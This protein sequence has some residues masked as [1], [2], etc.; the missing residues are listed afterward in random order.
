M[1]N[2]GLVSHVA[3]GNNSLFWSD[4]WL[5]G[6]CISD[7][8]PTVVEAVPLKTRQQRTVAEALLEQA[9][10]ADI[11]GC[12]SLSMIGLF[13]YFQLWDMMQDILLSKED[14]QHSWRLEGSGQFTSKS[15]YRAFF[16]GST[17]F[18]PWL[19]I[20]KTWDPG[21]CKVFLWLAIRN[22]CW[23]ADRLQKR[24]LPHPDKCVLCDQ[25]VETVQHI[26]TSCLFARDFW[27]KILAPL[28]LFFDEYRR[29]SPQLTFI[30]L[31]TILYNRVHDT[32][33]VKKKMSKITHSRYSKKGKKRS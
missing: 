28:D 29:G 1:F 12:L 8:A 2:I 24:G 17:T 15:A 9:W 5:M 33:K 14:N 22:R 23:T 30:N 16:N 32:K 21:K 27:F 11:Q 31:R 3:N 19:R 10:P 20:W 7:L 26:L 13:E 25:E 18:E 4:R 6:C